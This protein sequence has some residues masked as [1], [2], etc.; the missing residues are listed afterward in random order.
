MKTLYKAPLFVALVVLLAPLPAE[1]RSAL[2]N[3]IKRFA[4]KVCLGPEYGKRKA[5]C[6]RW[7]TS[8]GLSVL[9]A[10]REEKEVVENAVAE[11][12]AALQHTDIA[13][14][15]GD[16][17]SENAQIK[18]YCASY[19]EFPKIAKANN[20]RYHPGNIGYFWTFW[21][22]KHQIYRAVVLLASDRL[23]GDRRKHFVL[24]EIT[25]CLGLSNDS[26][27]YED[28]IFYQKDR[29]GGRATC[30]SDLDKKLI[31]FFYK[32]VSPGFNKRRFMRAL[33]SH[34]PEKKH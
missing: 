31:H 7:I 6:S 25:Q 33:R 28:S 16:D 21:N 26:Q 2:T 30:L 17:N 23:E 18:V 29:D 32:H 4:S 24:E 12:N 5:V 27:E 22:S 3:K 19:R 11:I 10:S 9:G 15:I 1:A 8:P 14:E 20:F 13:I 34:W